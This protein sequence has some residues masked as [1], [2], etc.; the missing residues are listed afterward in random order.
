MSTS[1]ASEER[2]SFQEGRDQAPTCSGKTARTELCSNLRAG[3]R[4]LNSILGKFKSIQAHR[5]HLETQGFTTSGQV[6]SCFQRMGHPRS[7]QVG[8][9]PKATAEGTRCYFTSAKQRVRPVG[10]Q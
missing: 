6:N 4:T 2:R 7:G 5:L 1:P 8:D 10:D 3:G 9:L